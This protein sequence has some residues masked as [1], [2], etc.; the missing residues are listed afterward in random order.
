MNLI[1][2]QQQCLLRLKI[3]N[4][5]KITIKYGK[6]IEKLMV[7]DFKTKPTDGD[8]DKYIKQK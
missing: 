1:K 4:F 8:D 3:K 5:L 2:G 6:K 7:V